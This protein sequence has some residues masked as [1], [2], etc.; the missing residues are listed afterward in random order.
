MPTTSDPEP[1]LRLVPMHPI[2]AA[3]VAAMERMDDIKPTRLSYNPGVGELASLLEDLAKWASIAD[4][5]TLAF[6]EYVRA[7]IGGIDRNQF[8]QCFCDQLRDAI[9]GNATFLISQAFER[10]WAD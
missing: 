3:I 4:S 6:G 8:E 1:H 5:V 10:W 2:R 7:E 9:D